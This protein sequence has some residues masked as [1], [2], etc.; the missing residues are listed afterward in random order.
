MKAFSNAVATASA[1]ENG[2][3]VRITRV[4]ARLNI[5]GPAAHIAA[6]M[7][8]LDPARFENH[9][10]V[11]RPGRDEGDMGYLIGEK[12][13]SP[14]TVI[15][16]LGRSVSPLRDLK[17]VAKLVPIL[18]RQRPHIVETHTAKAGFV[19]RLAARLAGVPVVLHVYHGHVFYGYFGRAQTRA[20][21]AIERLLARLSD[22]IVTI[23]AA[24][25]RDIAHVYRITSPD[26][27]VVVP[28]GFDLAGFSAAKRTA[29]GRF[30]AA[31][32]LAADVPLV[33]FVGRLTAVKDPA[34]F[35]K[36]AGRVLERVPDV[37]FVVVGDG[38]LRP[39]VEQQ[40][41]AS[42]LAERVQ[43]VGWQRDMPAVYAALDLLVL[44]SLNE[45]TPVT[46]IEA[47]AAGVPVVAT[48]VG[49][50]ADVV[51]DERTGLLIAAGDVDALASAMAALLCA[52][53]RGQ[54]LARA[55]QKDVLARFGRECL[56]DNMGSLYR[57]LLEEKDVL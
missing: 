9:L 52:P 54:V 34:L 44:T 55:G 8:G 47:L 53:E 42:G 27:V 6:L 35:V 28:L 24:Q 48:N 49:G 25:Q 13:L 4:I 36:A 57:S 16:E 3:R 12:G 30:R 14:P 40:V 2:P 5:G 29:M 18:R 51:S 43:L 33:G 26:K 46:V 56:I 19:G 10:I 50:V 41:A 31:Y 45:G 20:Y 1:I 15:P 38:E 37:H 17:T 11:G 39:D 7:S 21:I 22:R 32:G 23:S